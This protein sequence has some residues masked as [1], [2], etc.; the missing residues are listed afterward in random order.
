M[1]VRWMLWRRSSAAYVGELSYA[2]SQEGKQLII[3]FLSN[4]AY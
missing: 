3:T 1:S 4:G 2:K